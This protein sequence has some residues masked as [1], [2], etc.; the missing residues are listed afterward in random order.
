MVPRLL[1]LTWSPCGMTHGVLPGELAI[2]L[3]VASLFP[4]SPSKGLPVRYRRRELKDAARHR[5]RPEEPLYAGRPVCQGQPEAAGGDGDPGGLPAL[6]DTVVSE[7]DETS[8]H[9][10]AEVR[11]SGSAIETRK[12]KGLSTGM[13]GG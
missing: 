4:L 9:D 2:L 11:R 7:R 5:L 13:S 1:L 3:L 6:L 10:D 12:M 8:R